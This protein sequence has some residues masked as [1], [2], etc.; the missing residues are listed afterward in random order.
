MKP[1]LYL[2]LAVVIWNLITFL[3]MGF[4]KRRA[5]TGGWRVPEKRLF[6]CSFLFGGVGIALGMS[7]FRH[8]TQHLS[9][10]ILVPLSIFLNGAVVGTLLWYLQPWK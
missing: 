5:V 2:L 10:R 8:K 7:V 4:D 9:F 3:M 1:I 6:L